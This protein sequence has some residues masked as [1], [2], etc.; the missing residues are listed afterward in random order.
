MAWHRIWQ[1]SRSIPTLIFT[2]VFVLGSICG[3]GSADISFEELKTE[4]TAL[5]DA[6]SAQTPS[7]APIT[8]KQL[9][10]DKKN[11]L[12]TYDDMVND[13]AALKSM[14]PDIVTVKEL[15]TTF[16]TR[17]LYDIV[18]GDINSKNH[19]MIMGAMHAREYITTQLVM[20]QLT[21]YLKNYTS[22]AY[23]GKDAAEL[24]TNT[25]VH[26]IPMSNPDGV[27]VSQL[28]SSALKTDAARQFVDGVCASRGADAY[29]Q[30]K[31]NA[32]GV[33]INRNFDAG[34]DE[35]VGASG[36]SSDRYKGTAPGSSAEAAALISATEQ[37]N[38][39]RTIS[40]HTKGS[41]IYWYYKQTGAVKEKS[42]S[43]AKEISN[44]TGYVPDDN[45]EAVDAAG[46]K[47]WAV[48]KKGIPS[49]TIEVGGE[50]PDN[51][52]PYSYFENIYER[53]KDVVW[54]TLYG[55][56]VRGE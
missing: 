44:V 2:V 34:W 5:S 39:K 9:I 18:V 4:P 8:P 19:I 30:W 20:T 12:Y 41:L 25:A 29:V 32:E 37:Y 43:F 3:C 49:I 35:Y 53:N 45:Y 6:E 46:Y 24:T 38:F 11:S 42:E 10:I 56:S 54:E 7:P 26:F 51:P 50:A 23:K 14:Y 15:C 47:D 40:Y 27:T 13:I 31:A 16:D 48:Y 1:Y 55:L 22:F 21:D 36:P 33:D 17:K 52:V 28:G